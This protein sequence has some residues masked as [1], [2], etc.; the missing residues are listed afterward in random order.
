M[1][2]QTYDV[3]VLLGVVILMA[4]VIYWS[5]SYGAGMV[6]DIMQE[7]PQVLQSSFASYASLSCAID[8]N[9]TLEHRLIKKYPMYVT[10]NE[11]H[12]QIRSTGT[13]YG[14]TE[15]GGFIKFGARSAM[16]YVNCN[17]DTAR[18]NIRFNENVHS[19]V[20][21]TKLLDTLAIGVKV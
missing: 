11:S 20:T 5:V 10:M 4:V 16:P 1:S 19:A 18:K 6:A 17:M 2:T 9:F 7:A 13:V 8:G 15:R 3:V 21:L 12:V 14:E